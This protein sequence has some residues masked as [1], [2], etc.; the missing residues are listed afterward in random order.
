[1]LEVLL[2]VVLKFILRMANHHLTE[3][4]IEIESQ[5]D[6]TGGRQTCKGTEEAAR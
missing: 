3:T 4:T 1:M 5:T 6:E 2:E